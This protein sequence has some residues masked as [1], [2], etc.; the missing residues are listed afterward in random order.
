MNDLRFDQKRMEIIERKRQQQRAKDSTSASSSMLG[1]VRK[2]LSGMFESVAGGLNVSLKPGR[3]SSIH[4]AL[5]PKRMKQED[6]EGSEQQQLSPPAGS[7]SRDRSRSQSAKP[8]MKSEPR[9]T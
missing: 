7:R 2:N 6:I 5:S 4:G 8:E 1:N 9:S 3:S